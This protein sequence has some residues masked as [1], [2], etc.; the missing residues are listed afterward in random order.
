MNSNFIAAAAES[1]DLKKVFLSAAI[2]FIIFE[3]FMLLFLR[4]AIKSVLPAYLEL[5]YKCKKVRL[6]SRFLRKLAGDSATDEAPRIGV[7]FYYV[8]IIPLFAACAAM[9][10]LFAAFFV[11][12]ICGY[13]QLA[14]K[15]LI[16][17]Y[18]GFVGAVSYFFS[19]AN[20][21]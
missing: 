16:A 9:L 3:L 12:L 8:L 14:A 4:S 11:L 20:C 1:M 10:L 5:P 18:Y 19:A 21:F 7:A 15:A 6:R 2:C 13:L 17:A